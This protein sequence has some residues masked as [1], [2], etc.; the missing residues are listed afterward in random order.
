MNAG[1][2]IGLSK[3]KEK[4]YDISVEHEFSYNSN[5]TSQNNTRIHYNSNT[6][7]VNGTIYIKKVWSIVND[8]RFYSRQKTVQF[9]NN[10]N[11]HIWNARLQR[12]FKK[13]EFTAYFTVR[14]I[15]NQNIGIERNFNSNTYSEV[16]NDRLKRYFLIG[17]TWDFKN[18]GAKTK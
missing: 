1:L 7:S 10:L 9:N 16:T 6:L 12:T 18:K 4:K 17:F 8:Y 3:E 15:L 11:T 2:A 13:D 14:D 5:I